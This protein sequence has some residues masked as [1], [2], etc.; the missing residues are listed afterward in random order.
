MT[1]D[2]P[3]SSSSTTGNP[4][5]G[6]QRTRIASDQLATALRV[7][8]KVKPLDDDQLTNKD[9]APVKLDN[10]WDFVA[11]TAVKTAGAVQIAAGGGAAAAA[12][13]GGTVMAAASARGA[14][15]VTGSAAGG[16][17]TAAAAGDG[18]SEN[19]SSRQVPVLIWFQAEVVA[20]GGSG[21]ATL[22]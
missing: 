20:S 12:A 22:Y 13:G 10:G 4:L 17:R 9:H 14:A 21:S 19:L 3:T 15:S 2:H 11:A 16:L 5:G 7:Q 6:E 1:A 18:K 8:P